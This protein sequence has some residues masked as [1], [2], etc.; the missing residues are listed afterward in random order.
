MCPGRSQTLL[1][2]GMLVSPRPFASPRRSITTSGEGK[3]NVEL[4]LE[5]FRASVKY[6]PYY[7]HAM[8]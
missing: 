7:I 4:V 8:P 2:I 6:F 3:G 1:S 5:R